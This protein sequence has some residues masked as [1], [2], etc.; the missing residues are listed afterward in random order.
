MAAVGHELREK[1]EMGSCE[2]PVCK[3]SG[4]SEKKREIQD[5]RQWTRQKY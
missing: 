4:Q 1:L 5:G 3:K 2:Q